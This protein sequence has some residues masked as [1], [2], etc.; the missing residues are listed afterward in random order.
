M[1]FQMFIPI[2]HNI[3]QEKMYNILST[4]MLYLTLKLLGKEIMHISY[5]HGCIYSSYLL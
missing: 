2:G 5:I 1:Q 4:Q 3:N